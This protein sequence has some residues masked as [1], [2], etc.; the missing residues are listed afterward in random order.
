[1]KKQQATEIW[2]RNKKTAVLFNLAETKPSH[3]AAHCLPGNG[4]AQVVAF[5][6]ESL[7]GRNIGEG[8]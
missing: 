5:W 4:P 7:S 6:V 8:G 1:M 2:E 3:T